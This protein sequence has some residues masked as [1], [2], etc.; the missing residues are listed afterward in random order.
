MASA[1]EAQ[2]REACAALLPGLDLEAVT[3]RQVVHMVEARLGVLL[4]EKGS[5][6][7]NAVQGAIDA[8][9]LAAPDDKAAAAAGGGGG[10]AA[11][12]AAA[13]AVP[14]NARKRSRPASAKGFVV[15]D[16]EE[17]DDG[18]WN[19]D[20]EPEWDGEETD[21]GEDDAPEKPKKA[22]TKEERM[23][24]ARD[25]WAAPAPVAT[26]ATATATTA[27]TTMTATTTTTTAGA[28]A[29]PS[30]SA[31]DESKL[32]VALSLQPD[33]STAKELA[34]FLKLDKSAVNGALYRLQ[35]AGKASKT[36]TGG[37][38][39]WRSN[40]AAPP[41]APAPVDVPS[42]APTPTAAAPPP[43]SIS[44]PDKDAVDGQICAL[45]R[46][47][48]LVVGEYR[49]RKNVSLREYYEK[50]G[51]WLPGKKGISLA[52]EQWSILRD[53]IQGVNARVAAVSDGSYPQGGDECVVKLNPN[54]SRRVT[55]GTFRNATMVGVREFYEKDGKW[56]PGMKGISMPTEQW[57][58]VV[59]HAG[60]VDE[61]L[62]GA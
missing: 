23:N 13:G 40:S 2:V 15:D 25:K 60:K 14:P 35:S 37:A 12:A 51:K 59:K 34:S 21:E 5:D 8:F 62:G 41:A 19:G 28:D 32:L 9:L 43:S 16:E 20:D 31:V 29:R 42:S 17:E 61:A 27:T 58:Q 26:A 10:A 50:D 7:R 3:E 38:P 36:E 39:T 55:V 48:R 18:E 57:E 33:G 44:P 46:Q 24:A 47:K 54:G 56:L 11:A 6:L 22:K 4:G 30:S 1:T 49:G 53:S 52:P 45:S